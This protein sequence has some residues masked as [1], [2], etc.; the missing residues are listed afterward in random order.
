MRD[1]SVTAP[2]SKLL[3]TVHVATAVSV[4]GTDLVLGI[5]SVR[6]VDPPGFRP[7]RHVVAGPADTVGRVQVLVGD[8]QAGAHGDPD[9]GHLFR[10]RTRAR[11]TPRTQP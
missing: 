7:D 2:R 5:A 3:L 6:G 1:T 8:D 9:R 11:R 10:A 4:L